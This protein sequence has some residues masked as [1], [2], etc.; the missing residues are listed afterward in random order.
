MSR[1]PRAYHHGDLRQALVAEAATLVEEEGLGALTLRELARRLGVSHAAPKNHF[2]D[3]DALLGELAADGFVEM[4]A[5][6]A[7]ATVGKSPAA[8][9]RATGRAYID[10]ALRRPGHFRVMFGRGASP[11][12]PRLAEAGT[13]AFSIL[14]RAVAATLPPARARSAKHIAEAAFLAWSTVHGAAMLIL[15]APLSPLL[16]DGTTVDHLVDAALVSIARAVN[17]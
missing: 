5:D 11:P 3:K 9:L 7:A 2:A 14:E 6:L 4:A 10:F 12:S 17:V 8:D 13:L 15:E 1:A 16:T